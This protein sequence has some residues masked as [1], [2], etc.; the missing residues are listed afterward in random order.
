M[1]KLC[2]VE[3]EVAFTRCDE[4]EI[5]QPTYFRRKCAS[6]DAEEVRELLAIEWN[7]EFVSAFLLCEKPQVGHQPVLCG[8]V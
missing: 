6:L 5:G 3:S 2:A 8:P 4:T 7:V 1:R